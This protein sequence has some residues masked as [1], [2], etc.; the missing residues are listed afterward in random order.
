MMHKYLPKDFK[1]SVK[2]IMKCLPSKSKKNGITDFTSWPLG[3][4][5]ST[6]GLNNYSESLKAMI[7][8]TKVF[9]SEFTIRPFIE[10]YQER[11]FQDLTKLLNHKDVHVRRLI[12]EGTRPLLPW[13]IK[14]NNIHE[15]IER[16]IPILMK[17]FCD[18]EKYVRL[19]VANHL[20]DISKLDKNLMI[21]TCKKML[22]LNPS[23]E[24]VW[25]VKHATRS[26]LKSGNIEA[27][28]LNGYTK[29]PQIN[30][31]KLKLSTRTIKEND[32][33]TLNFDLASEAKKD[34]KLLIEYIIHYPK[35]N[36]SLSPKPFRLKDF[37]LKSFDE[38]EVEK[39]VHFKKV[40]TRVHYRGKHLIEIQINGK[41]VA[42]DWFTLI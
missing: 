13:G 20:N 19:S 21:D 41:I 3:E 18:E 17:L 37:V 1:K 27:L 5:V 8:L 33:F 30:I 4:Y 36:G 7:E 6:Y 23:E 11:I 40:T 28:S 26:L 2:I 39:T 10:K 32:R 16:N 42:K 15:N 34:Q 22:K 14:V 38:M 9:T 12:S 29:K 24:T 35:K 31:K 25:L